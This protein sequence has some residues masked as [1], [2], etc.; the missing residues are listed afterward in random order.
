MIKA[1]PATQPEFEIIE[2]T[3]PEEIAKAKAQRKKSDRNFAWF[4]QRSKEIYERYRGKCV[5]I[6]GEELFV[7][8]S[9][10]EA[11]ALGRTAHPDDD[12]SF[13]QYIPRKLGRHIYANRRILAGL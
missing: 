9:A 5:C 13:V 8:D 3:D 11:K 12:G 1:R 4:Q 7:A 10:L 6:A 2:V